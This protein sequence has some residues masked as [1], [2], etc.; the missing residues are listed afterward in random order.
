M[1]NFIRTPRALLLGVVA[2]AVVLVG[3]GVASGT[4]GAKKPN[5]YW[6]CVPK[7]GR[8]KLVYPGSKCKKGERLI[9]WNQN[10]P[11][12]ATVV[13]DGQQGPKGDTGEQGPAGS[14][15]AQGPAGPKG[16]AGAPGAKGADG[17]AGPRGR[18]R[19][20][21]PAGATP[22]P[23]G[24]TVLTVSTALMV[25]LARRVTRATLVLRV[26]LVRP[27][28]KGTWR[29]GSEGDAAE[30]DKGDLPVSRAAGASGFTKVTVRT[31][32]GS[33]NLEIAAN[34]Q[35]GETAVG[36]GVAPS[37]NREVISTYPNASDG[38][39]PTGL[40]RWV[41]VTARRQSRST[42]SARGG[43]ARERSDGR[44]PGLPSS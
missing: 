21:R 7:D 18:R 19:R 43:A 4:I 36:G 6:A 24:S 3:A 39:S 44:P 42:C 20:C 29:A 27:A 1:K 34:C 12:S 33:P 40:D 13:K 26:R 25:L 15:G 32:T 2:L 31:A 10:G 22:A 9:K 11:E 17:A 35:T 5:V 8:I 30:G 37:N 41:Q 16:D 38:G 14:A 28:L 23:M